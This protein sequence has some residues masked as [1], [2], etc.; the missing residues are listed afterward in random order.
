M[1]GII[2]IW[3]TLAPNVT[4]AEN[5]Q[6]TTVDTDA[7]L[8]SQQDSLNIS[9]FLKE[10]DRYTESVFENVDINELFTS[11]LTGKIDNEKLFKGI[12]NFSNNT[13]NENVAKIAD[14]GQYASGHLLYNN[15]QGIA[16]LAALI[17]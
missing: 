16:A 10:A 13:Y 12:L 6:E 4:Y 1:I 5:S 15:P 3:F 7:I 2:L 11:A 17:K 9:S 8:Q 14:R